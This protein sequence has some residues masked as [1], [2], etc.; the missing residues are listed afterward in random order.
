MVCYLILPG[1]MFESNCCMHLARIELNTYLWAIHLWE[2]CDSICFLI[3]WQGKWESCLGIAI[4]SWS[5]SI[6]LN[7]WKIDHKL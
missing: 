5:C 1:W 4:F 7:I 2:I 6:S 3:V